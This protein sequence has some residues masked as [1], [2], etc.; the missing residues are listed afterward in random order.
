M[1]SLPSAVWR[2]GGLLSALTVLLLL[3]CDGGGKPATSTQPAAV[4][5]PPPVVPG[6]PMEQ[7]QRPPSQPRSRGEVAAEALPAT[8]AIPATP[9]VPAKP[10]PPRSPESVAVTPLGIGD[11]APPLSIATWV[12]GDAVEGFEAGGVTVV[13]FW[14]TWCGPCLASM[15]HISELQKQY[16]DAVRF[17]GVT[18]EDRDVVDAFLAKEQREGATW[19]DVITYRLVIDDSDATNNAYMRAAGQ[20][21]IPCAFIVGKSG[22]VEWIGHPMQIDAPLEAIV[23]DSYD[24]E[25]AV[26]EFAAQEWLKSKQ[27]E[28]FTLQREQKWDEALVLLDT[29]QSELDELA[30]PYNAQRLLSMKLGLLSGAGRTDEA[31]ALRGELVEAGWDEP[32]LLNEL[33]WNTALADEPSEADLEIALK[34][35]TRAAELT[36]ETDGSI[37]DTLARVHYGLGDLDQAISWQE[38]AVEHADGNASILQTLEQ[39]RAERESAGSG[40][41]LLEGEAT[42]EVEV[43]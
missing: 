5:G 15:P 11:A 17:I 6:V 2:C 8:P 39:Y 20:N 23:N 10:I 3:G 31:T 32:Q 13:E 21:G 36:E 42:V 37:L 26:A 41:Q 12:T 9:L 40:E 24:R 4:Q 38:K 30:A 29:I 7:R 14:A 19:A 34:A 22:L 33:A 35:A 25:A 1:V 27:Q 16:G 18:R 43:R 28:L